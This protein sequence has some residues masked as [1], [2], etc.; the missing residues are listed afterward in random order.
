MLLTQTGAYRLFK[1][2][3][4]NLYSQCYLLF[5]KGDFTLEGKEEL[6]MLIVDHTIAVY[7]TITT[8][9]DLLMAQ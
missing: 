3:I 6:G 9:V 8:Q 7:N 2:Q 1:I 5:F 4:C